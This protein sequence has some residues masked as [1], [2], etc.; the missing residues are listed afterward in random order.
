MNCDALP[1][2]GGPHLPLLLLSAACLVAGLLLLFADRSRRCKLS[3]IAVA[4]FLLG[5]TVGFTNADGMA[6]HAS[7]SD[8]VPATTGPVDSLTITQTSTIKG[9]A[10]GAPPVP[11][12]GVV[13]NHGSDSAYITAV[14]VRIESVVKAPNSVSGR[15]DASDYVLLAPRMPLNRSIDSRSAEDFAGASIGFRNKST[16]QDACQRATVKL[17]YRSF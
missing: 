3:A 15:C 12:T 7:A 9:L 11:I 5:G 6:A 1:D 2:T 14:T 4:L 17:R 10:P 13:A 16:I 8:C